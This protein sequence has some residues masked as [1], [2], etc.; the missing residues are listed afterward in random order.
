MRAL[1]SV[2]DKTDLVNFAEGLRGLGVELLA[3]GKTHKVLTDNNIESRE[4]ATLTDTPEMLDGRV[5]T[6]HPA[7]HAGIL[8]DR[9]KASHMQDLEVNG[10]SPIDIVVCNLYPFVE[11][12]GIEMID[13]GGPTMVRAAA[14]NHQCVTVIVDPSDY[15]KVLDELRSLGAVSPETR[16]MLA[17]KAFAHT[18]A[19]DAAIVSWFDEGMSDDESTQLPPT[20]HLSIAKAE[21]LRY[22]E[23]PHQVGARY[24][25]INAKPSV[26]DTMTQ[27]S[28]K[29]L[30][31]LNLFDAEAAW[32]LAHDVISLA[33]DKK[34]GVVIVKHANPCGVAVGDNIYA[35]YE[36]AYNADPLSA[37]G[38]IVAI[39]ATLDMK[40]AEAI[41]AN[42]LCDVLVAYHVDEDALAHIAGKRK[43]TRI[44]TMNPPE[45]PKLSLRQ[46]GTDFLVQQP[47]TFVSQKSDFR[48]VTHTEPNEEQ[49]NDLELAWRT[50][51]RTTSNAITI[52]ANGQVNGIGCGQQSRVDAAVLACK[53]AGERAHGAVAASDA[54]FP[55]RDGLD[56]LVDAG[57]TAVI[58]PGGSL[59]DEEVI[60]AANERGI[61][62]VFTAE[63]HF[64]H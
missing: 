16:T 36:A 25:L 33:P 12:P 14:K 13:V 8:A 64:R 58:Q 49:W 20:L 11:S 34:S 27:L 30:S 28:G 5:K 48:V 59:R 4:V 15:G 21:A 62:M 18:A 6:L 17:R 1:L 61:T 42:H 45:R 54:Y 23:N 60:N 2:Y 39:P 38:G 9:N 32:V 47:D 35:A 19:Y 29:E 63:R 41:A 50:C 44:L 52:A 26:F 10:I 40:L 7:I 57:V 43:N 53:K 3:S 31:Y 55:F 51:A 56:V 46:L 37:F 24:S 22:G